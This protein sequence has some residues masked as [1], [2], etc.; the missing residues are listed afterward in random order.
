MQRFIRSTV[1]RPMETAPATA[2]NGTLTRNETISL[3]QSFPHPNSRI[4]GDGSDLGERT[5][6][7]LSFSGTWYA[8]YQ[9]STRECR[10]MLWWINQNALISTKLAM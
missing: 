8:N 1:V 3:T 2:A 10:K 5:T 9:V 6:S 4:G 7:F